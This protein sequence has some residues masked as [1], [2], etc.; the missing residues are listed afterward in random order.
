MN[1]GLII[2][3]PLLG[4][5]LPLIAGQTRRRCAL[6]AA[7]APLL[8]LLWTLAQAPHLLTGKVLT[9]ELL[10]AE[11]LRASWSW[12]PQLGLNISFRLDGLALLF[13]LLILG[14]GLLVILYAR[15]YLSAADSLPR[16]YALLLLF[17]SAM[18]GVVTADNL[19]LL[20]VFWELTSLTSFLLIGYWSQHSDA[21]R[22]ARLA[23]S[24][25][26]AGGLSLLA[27]VLILGNIAGSFDLDKVFAA[28][29]IIQQHALYPCALLLILLGAFTKSAQFPF[30]FWL[31][32]A[33]A[34]PTPV[35]AYLHSA[36]MV[37][38][39]VFL[40][41]RLYPVL[42]GSDYW[43]YSVAGTGLITLL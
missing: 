35:S 20:C 25:T 28:R 36:T 9:D 21:R 17:M 12:L 23:L 18:L 24:V 29:A 27:G 41:A 16:L 19:L 38:L 26:G 30:Y 11:P 7:S 13:V 42:A 40:L 2:I 33:M 5:A 10:A 4:A 32:H 1:L 31:P 8:A 22:G 6:A 34:A 3:L 14:I 15:Y 43:F 37:K 39:G